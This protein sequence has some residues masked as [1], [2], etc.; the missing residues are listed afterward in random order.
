[1]NK[2]DRLPIQSTLLLALLF[3]VILIS[4]DD[5]NDDVVVPPPTPTNQSFSTSFESIDSL[6]SQG[7]IF[8]NLSDT[9][10]FGPGFGWSI[11]P[12]TG[13]GEAPYDGSSLLYD[14]YQAATNF[15]GN[16]SDWLIS[17]KLYFQNGDKISFYTL[18]HGSVGYGSSGAFGDRLQLRLNIFN[19][20]A[21]IGAA[22][23]DVGNFT[24]PVIDI[25]PL[26]KVSPPGDYPSTWTKYEATIT[27]LNQPD[28]GR[29]AL[30]YF[31]ELN[32]GANGDEIGVDKLE[33][34]SATK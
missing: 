15:S 21:D 13:N 29:F 20:S 28:S 17:P 30:R 6:E 19:T 27:G 18:S 4:C 3:S 2:L 34:T 7:W 11:Q 23:T 5:N 22:S 24:T 1:M 8:T 26:Y 16:I 25:N 9:I 33:F 12:S 31:V 14:S 32:G 10:G